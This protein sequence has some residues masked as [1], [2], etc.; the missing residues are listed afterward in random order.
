MLLLSILLAGA[1]S[2]VFISACRTR[3]IT[4]VHAYIAQAAARPTQPPPDNLDELINLNTATFQQLDSLPGIGEKTA[5][6]ILN[7]RAELGAF[8]YK[9]E[10]LLIHGLGEK[11][12]DAIYHLIYVK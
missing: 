10:L 3:R 5:N 6:A 12:L 1:L 8:R 9:E 7:L 11:K 4:A 2:C